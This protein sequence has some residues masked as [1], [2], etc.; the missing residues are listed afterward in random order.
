MTLLDGMFTREEAAAALGVHPS[1]VTRMVKAG[2]LRPL[3]MF[4]G[5]HYLYDKKE[6][7]AVKR[8][9]YPEGMTYMEIAHKYGVARNTVKRNFKRAGLRPKGFQYR[10]QTPVFDPVLVDVVA[11]SLGW[12]ENRTD[13]SLAP[14]S[15][16]A[17]DR[18]P[19][20]PPP[21][22]SLKRM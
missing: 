4:V 19:S 17:A 16:D 13:E 18:E 22:C 15:A 8:R 12:L 11:H 2:T 21:G 1:T 14:A 3:L 6:V 7:E 5:R 9:L 10:S 20:A